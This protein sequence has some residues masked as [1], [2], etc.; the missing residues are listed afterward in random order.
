[1]Q[2]VNLKYSTEYNNYSGVVPS[3]TGTI[4]SINPNEIAEGVKGFSLEIKEDLKVTLC[5]EDG[6]EVSSGVLPAGT[7]LASARGNQFNAERHVVGGKTSFSLSWREGEA[8]PLINLLPSEGVIG[9]KP[10]MSFTAVKA[11]NPLLVTA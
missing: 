10:V 9:V 3:V 2:Q 7:Y 8:A 11:T 1:M 4:T 5:D 6:T